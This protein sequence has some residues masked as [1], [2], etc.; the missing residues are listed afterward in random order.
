MKPQGEGTGVDFQ[1]PRGEDAAPG[2]LTRIDNALDDIRAGKR[3]ILVDDEDQENKGNLTIAADQVTPEIVNSMARHGRG[4][5][6]LTIMEECARRLRLPPMARM[7]DLRQFA[8]R[9]GLRVVERVP[10]DV[11][12]NPMN[13]RYLATKKE[14][15]GHLLASQG[16]S[17]PVFAV[18]RDA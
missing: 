13:A 12:S 14:K 6:C 10:V 15:M 2:V 11:V 5:I 4:L 3:V 16:D 1:D 17:M 8:V 18:R 9:H 7:P